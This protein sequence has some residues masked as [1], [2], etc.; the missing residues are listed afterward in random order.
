MTMHPVDCLALSDHQLIVATG[1][2][3]PLHALNRLRLGGGEG[4]SP[5]RQC[6]DEA[7]AI[8]QSGVFGLTNLLWHPDS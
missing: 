4:F 1:G 8:A 3:Q 7:E 5:F 6:D 2:S